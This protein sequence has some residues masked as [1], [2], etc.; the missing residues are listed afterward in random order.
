MARAHRRR[1]R[2]NDTMD[3]TALINEAYVKLADGKPIEFNDR[4]H[5]FATASR[6]MRQVL[7]NY[8]ER[9]GAEKRGGRAIRL[10][11]SGDVAAFDDAIG[12]LLDI[13]A[14]LEKVENANER[15]ARLFE[16][17]VFGGMTIEETALVLNVSPATVKRD[18]SLVSAW[19]Y[20]ELRSEPSGDSEANS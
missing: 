9:A 10:T 13:N 19:V 2:G 8:S 3:T 12:E 15:Y 5:F 1:W 16:C 18:W 7:I 4:A 14:L 11:L 17:R 6:A 20:R